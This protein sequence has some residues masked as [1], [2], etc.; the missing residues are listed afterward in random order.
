MIVLALLGALSAQY[1]GVATPREPLPV[2]YPRTEVIVRQYSDLDPHA[3]LAKYRKEGLFPLQGKLTQARLYIQNMDADDDQ[4]Y[5]L[6]LEDS[7]YQVAIVMK[8]WT[9]NGG[10][11]PRCRAGSAAGWMNSCL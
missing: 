5:L 4:E 8:Q 7:S 3:S 11:S 6:L 1:P 10:I 9:A 2:E